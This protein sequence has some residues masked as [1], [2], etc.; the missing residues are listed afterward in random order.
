MSGLFDI[1]SWFLGLN[2]LEMF[3]VT[4]AVLGG[5]VFLVRIVLLFFVGDGDAVVDDVGLDSDVGFQL[6]SIQGLSGFF[7]MFGL[8][9][10]ALIQTGV[11]ELLTSLWALVA[12]GITILAVAAL[13]SVMVRLQSSG[14][15]DIANTLGSE[16][17]VYL[18]IPD[19]GIGRARIRTRDRLRTY[20]A[21]SKT[22][23][24]LKTGTP[25]RVA[26]VSGNMLVVEKL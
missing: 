10:L 2:V 21:T 16:G 5:L 19:N 6:L 9:G 15:V 22:K 25:I 17:T 26:Q 4:S 3:Y 7:V 24:E 13:S 20:D 12:E 18:T 14:N 23:E 11:S 1:G 8:V